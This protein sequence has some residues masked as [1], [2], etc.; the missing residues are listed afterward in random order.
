MLVSCGCHNGVAFVLLFR[1]AI[2]V[3]Y[4]ACVNKSDG[5]R[6]VYPHTGTRQQEVEEDVTAISQY[7]ARVLN[8]SFGV[9]G[10]A[11]AVRIASFI[12]EIISNQSRCI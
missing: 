5:L 10:P 1:V 12:C 9:L 2:G 8:V 11:I 6:V 3:F 4:N 7:H